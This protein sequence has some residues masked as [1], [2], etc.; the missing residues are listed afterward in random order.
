VSLLHLDAQSGLV[1]PK[2]P[3]PAHQCSDAAESRQSVEQDGGWQPAKKRQL[4]LLPEAAIEA[5]CVYAIDLDGKV[6]LFHA[7]YTV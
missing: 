2:P 7:S 5:V 3:A 4:R 6:R 1:G